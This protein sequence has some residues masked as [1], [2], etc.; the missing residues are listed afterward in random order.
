MFTS[1]GFQSCGDLSGQRSNRRERL[2]IQ[3]DGGVPLASWGSV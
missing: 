1:G 2:K 3:N